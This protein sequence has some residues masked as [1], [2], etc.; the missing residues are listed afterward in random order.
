MKEIVDQPIWERKWVSREE[1]AKLF[2]PISETH[3]NY[4]KKRI[5]EGEKASRTYLMRKYQLTDH[6]ARIFLERLNG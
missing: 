5:A 6:D 1:A 3:F 4:E 2:S